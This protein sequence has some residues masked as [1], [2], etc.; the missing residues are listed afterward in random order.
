M[1]KIQLLDKNLINKIAAGEVVERPASVVKELIENSLDA[2]ASTITIE[3]EEGGIHLIRVTDNGCGM[4]P[5]DAEKCLEKHATSKIARVEDLHA[6]TTMGFRGEALAAISSVSEFLLRTRTEEAV[7]ATEVKAINGEVSVGQGAGVKGTM[8][9]VKGLFHSV[10]ARKKFLKA[11]STEYRNIVDVVSAQ[12]MLTP[13]IS[14]KLIHNGKTTLE[15]QAVTDVKDR[16]VQ[17]LGKELGSNLIE[18]NHQR[19]SLQLTGFISHPSLSQANSKD[20]YLFV[21]GRPIKDYILA[22]AIKDGYGTHLN[23]LQKPAFV[24]QISIAPDLVDVNVHP[25]KSEVKFADTSG[26]YRELV[27]AVKK[28]LENTEEVAFQ[29]VA[30]MPAMRKPASPKV[31][32]DLKTSATQPSS[33]AMPIFRPKMQVKQKAFRQTIHQEA[34]VQEEV[35]G[36]KLLG[37]IHDSYLVLETP[38]GLMLLDQHAV[39]EKVL[40]EELLAHQEVSK[41]QQLLVPIVIELSAKQQ[42]FVQDQQDVLEALGVEGEFFGGSSFRLTGLPQEL[43][44]K[45]IKAFFMQLLDDLEHDGIGKA[46]SLEKRKQQAAKYMACRGAVMFG[47]PLTREEQLQLVKSMQ[48]GQI[49]TCI[50]GRAAVFELSKDELNKK[51][52][53]C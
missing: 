1:P 2:G 47:D 28:A 21:N 34:V 31:S 11:A 33:Q 36:Y 46:D 35:S 3:L 37:Q 8:I 5:Y 27:V 30:S 15:L 22:K 17:M 26:I 19:A 39:A 13:Q 45:D 38:T 49:M 51:F 10:P 24:M 29:S 40:Y 41:I 4:D 18:V 6:L 44:V 32:Y 16:V 7:G 14:W 23:N 43:A 20:Q 53:R 42:S 50:H 52:H 25:R 48:E 9:E 12:A